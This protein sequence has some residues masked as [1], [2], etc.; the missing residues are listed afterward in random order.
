MCP[1]RFAWQARHLV[2]F[3]VFQEGVCAHSRRE[4]KV[5]VSRGK[6]GETTKACLSCQKMCSCRFVQAL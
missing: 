2:T 6:H 3:D 1:C 4:G 5:G